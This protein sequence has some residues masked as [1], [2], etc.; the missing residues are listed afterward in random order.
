MKKKSGDKWLNY[1]DH[2]CK[3]KGEA[4][5]LVANLVSLS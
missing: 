2:K 1:S 3:L 5:I 4:A